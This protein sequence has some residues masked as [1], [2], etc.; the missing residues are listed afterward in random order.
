MRKYLVRYCVGRNHI[1]AIMEGDTYRAVSTRIRKQCRSAT[2]FS[3]QDIAQ[4]KSSAL[5]SSITGAGKGV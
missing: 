1:Q 4:M 5:A 3:I 2:I